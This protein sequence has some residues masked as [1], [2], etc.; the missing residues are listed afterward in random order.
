MK[1]LINTTI[2]ETDDL[3]YVSVYSDKEIIF[4]FKSSEK[5]LTLNFPN[6]EMMLNTFRLIASKLGFN[7]E[8]FN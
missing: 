7:N 8:Q 6:K 3:S 4:A 5:T 1:I 2:I